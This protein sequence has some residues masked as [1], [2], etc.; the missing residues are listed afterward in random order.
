MQEIGKKNLGEEYKPKRGRIIVR[1]QLKPGCAA[2]CKLS[3]NRKFSDEDRE[4]I[5]HTF[6]SLGDNQRQWDFLRT[7]EKKMQNRQ[8]KTSRREKKLGLCGFLR[9]IKPFK[10]AK[11]F[12]E[13]LKHIRNKSTD[14]AE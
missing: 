14:I 8:S 5:F 11:Y 7:L 12:Y 1:R 2:S 13:H 3:C 9:K 6:W 4:S 10:Y